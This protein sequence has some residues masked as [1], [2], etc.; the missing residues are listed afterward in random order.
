MPFEPQETVIDVNL[1]SAGALSKV[2][3]PGMFAS[4]DVDV[5]VL[6]LANKFQLMDSA[7]IA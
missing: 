3:I 4:V 6:E 7:P 5:T 1:T 2:N